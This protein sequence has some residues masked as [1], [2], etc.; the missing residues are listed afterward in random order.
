[1][2]GCGAVAVAC[3]AEAVADAVA[4]GGALE[5]AE[6]GAVLFGGVAG[7]CPEAEAAKNVADVN[8]N[9]IAVLVN[10][11]SVDT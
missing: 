11:R 7:D 6:I 4:S 3:C 8:A 9:A 5:A 1:L 2:L 10:A